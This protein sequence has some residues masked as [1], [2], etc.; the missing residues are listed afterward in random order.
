M[1]QRWRRRRW[2]LG[3]HSQLPQ[4][5]LLS[6]LITLPMLV[7]QLRLRQRLQL[8]AWCPRCKG[9]LLRWFQSLWFRC[10]KT[11]RDTSR[12]A[13]LHFSASASAP[14]AATGWL[15]LVVSS[16]QCGLAAQH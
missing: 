4:L 12:P 1:A 15:V 14:L 8:Q 2:Q 3:S 10:P 7:L 16:V 6:L 11:C 9:F 13:A 5:S